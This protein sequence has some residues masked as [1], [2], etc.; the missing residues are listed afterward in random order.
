MKLLIANAP[1]FDGEYEMETRFTMRER[2]R[3]RDISN[4]HGYEM[5]TAILDEHPGLAVAFAV[6]ALQREHDR[7][8][9]GE[10]IDRLWDAP[11]AEIRLVFED[12]ARP[13]EPSEPSASGS[14]KNE[15]SGT[16][17]RSASGS[18]D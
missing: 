8:L 18:Q 11:D 15:S 9:L 12:D 1:P 16:S 7:T 6:I 13:P 4:L 10:E 3:I 5:H 14:E 2:Q 17:S